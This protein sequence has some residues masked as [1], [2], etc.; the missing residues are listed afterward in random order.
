ME[1]GK[2]IKFRVMG[3]EHIYDGVMTDKYFFVDREDATDTYVKHG[4]IEGIK[5]LFEVGYWIE[6]LP[7]E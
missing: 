4:D 7:T 2:H 5:D 3:D 6:I 1:I